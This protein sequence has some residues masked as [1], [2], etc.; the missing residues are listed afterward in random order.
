MS[1]SSPVE[2]PDGPAG[3]RCHYG[4]M[5]LEADAFDAAA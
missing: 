4:K 5:T 1:R 2:G 3:A